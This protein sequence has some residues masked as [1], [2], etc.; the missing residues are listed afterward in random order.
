MADPLDSLRLP[1][2]PVAPDPAFRDRLRA[3]WSG[4]RP[5]PVTPPGLVP[6]PATVPE[7]SAWTGD[8]VA[9]AVAELERLDVIK[10]AEAT[11]APNGAR[12]SSRPA[13]LF[14]PLAERNGAHS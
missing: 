13:G 6:T 10:A 3:R 2:T 14:V 9:H 5:S 1:P 7:I 8:L 12:P 11:E 4:A